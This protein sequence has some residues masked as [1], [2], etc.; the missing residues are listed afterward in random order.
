MADENKK[1]TGLGDSEA[2]A[3]RLAD[4]L[5]QSEERLKQI[6]AIATE[7]KDS[8][9][10]MVEKISDSARSGGDFTNSIKNSASLVKGMQNDAKLLA[11]FNK[12]NLKTEKDHA[13]LE[14][15][16]ATFK[17]KMVELDSQIKFLT[18]A[19]VN[20]TVEERDAINSTLKDLT[21]AKDKAGELADSFE[22]I[23]EANNKINSELKAS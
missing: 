22:E 16:K 20:A 23:A 3:L 2:E 7:A 21:I 6:N 19:R 12:D 13:K 11:G 18:E 8:F 17:N 10:S 14:K 5:G 1:P 4:A 15:R 9:S